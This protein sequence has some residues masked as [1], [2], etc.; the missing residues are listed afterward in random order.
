MFAQNRKRLVPAAGS[1]GRVSPTRARLDSDALNSAPSETALSETGDDAGN[2]TVP[3]E[4][5]RERG[6]Q[7][8][9]DVRRALGLKTVKCLCQASQI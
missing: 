2:L 6:N 8:P 5:T 3:G 9:G 7:A 4:L 1:V